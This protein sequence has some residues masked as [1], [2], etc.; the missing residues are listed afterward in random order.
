TP[1]DP[2]LI[3]V[4][5]PAVAKAGMKTGVARRPIIDMEAYEL[6]LKSRM[7]PTASILQGIHARA[8]A[9][10]ARMIFAEGDDPRVLRA[11]VAYQR[12]GLGKALVV[13]R[14][15]DVAEKLTA[16]GLADAVK[17]LEIVNAA[18]TTHLQT[19]KD[20]LYTR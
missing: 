15:A 8:R 1:F 11:A 13:G 5:P 3:H 12:A 2:R 7:D 17:E 20:F 18:N 16:E 14:E 9:A 6:H 4:I 10:Q 19:Y